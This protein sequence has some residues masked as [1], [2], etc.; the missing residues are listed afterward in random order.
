MY[1][2]F[3]LKTGK[4]EQIECDVRDVEDKLK[5]MD[6][7]FLFSADSP[8]EYQRKLAKDLNGKADTY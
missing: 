8:E 7:V 1:H 4:V 5:D 3:L 2:A 6:A